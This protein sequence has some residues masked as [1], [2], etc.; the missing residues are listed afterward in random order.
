MQN[1]ENQ[2]KIWAPHICCNTCATN[3]RQWLNK[4]GKCMP[5]AVPM[6]W[7]NP[8]DHI[9]DC[10]FCITPP[11]SKELS[12]KKK[13]GIQYP[14]IPSAICPVSHGEMLPVPKAPEKY[15]L[16]SDKEEIESSASSGEFPMSSQESYS[17]SSISHKAH[18]I[19][20]NELNDLVR[21]L[22]LPKTNSELLGS[23]LQ[24]WNLLADGVRISK[25][26]DR[27]Q[28]LESFYFVDGSPVVCP[29][30]HELMAALKI[31]YCVIHLNEV[32]S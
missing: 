11:V 29:K 10:Y 23:R 30:V 1:F 8:T 15:N 5:F 24:Q 14:N 27:Q 6:I 12:R 4:K 31:T 32:C 20:Q 7:K 22:E 26:R 19:S 3:L 21:D 2:D 9:S 18:F 28:Q 16:D 17:A 25:Y 13:H